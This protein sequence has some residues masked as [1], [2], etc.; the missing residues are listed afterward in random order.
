MTG[1]S[2]DSAAVVVDST[3]EHKWQKL[4]DVVGDGWI[5]YEWLGPRES[6]RRLLLGQS[7]TTLDEL[8]AQQT[9]LDVS[10]DL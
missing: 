1:I 6:V 8:P 2:T 10:Q 9:S 7:Y 5:A 3:P 4:K